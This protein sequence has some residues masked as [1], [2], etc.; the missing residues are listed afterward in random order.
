VSGQRQFRMLTLHYGL[1]QLS[2][3]MAGGFVGAYLLELGFSFPVAL[4][5]YAVLLLARFGV[6][7]LTL[8]VVRRLG[9]RKAIALGACV[10][11]A[12]FLPLFFA[13]RPLGLAAWLLTVAIGESLYWPTYHAAM[14]ATGGG[15]SRGREL[16]VRTAVGAIVGIVGPLCGGV[17]LAQFGPE[18][19]FSIAAALCLAAAAAALALGDLSI[20]AIPTMR[21]SLRA[22]DLSGVAAFAADGWMAS[23]LALAWPMALFISLGFRYEAFGVA[24]AV[25]GVAGAATGLACGG[26]IDRGRRDRYLV[27]VSWALVL[28]F[29]L[30]ACAN[31]SALAAEIANGTGAAVMGLYTP[32]LMTGVYER[33][34]RSG[35]AY[36]FHFAAEAGWDAGAAL[37]C[38]AC[39]AT[40][41]ATRIPSLSVLPAALGVIALY[42][43]VRGHDAHGR[44][45][46]EAASG[47]TAR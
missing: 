16:G 24:N 7:F 11:G 15:A 25:A 44:G 23:G 42:V 30:R 43:C 17:L 19:D 37:G 35:E 38:L 47:A 3:A 1:Y 26:S 14:A 9:P 32:V 20:G 40:A 34:K 39:A 18:A 2:I 10:A 21:Q 6:R 13:A 5:A 12:Q 4:A 33:A 36:R 28:S 22:I 8:A 27:I 41:W 45:E 29:G 31:W 46:F